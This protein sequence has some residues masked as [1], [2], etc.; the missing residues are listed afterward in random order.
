MADTENFEGGAG[1]L[2]VTC[3]QQGG[4]GVSPSAQ[5]A[6]AEANYKSVF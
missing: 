4:G 5:S 6:E 3:S 2:L 1:Q